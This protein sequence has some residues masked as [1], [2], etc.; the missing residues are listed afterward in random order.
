MD[1]VRNGKIVGYSNYF[2]EHGD[3]KMTIKNYTKFNVEL[4]GVKIFSILCHHRW[5][6]IREVTSQTDILLSMQTST[7]I[8]LMK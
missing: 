3:K 4:L 7:Q 2:F 1:V 8:T 6:K 5:E